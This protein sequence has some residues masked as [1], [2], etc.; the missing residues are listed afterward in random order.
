MASS[1]SGKTHF[2][3]ALL[4]HL[5]QDTTNYSYL[6]IYF[7]FN[8]DTEYLKSEGNF[9]PFLSRMVFE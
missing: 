4:R 7:S 2:L 1:G 8:S 5:T 3:D 9:D 6:P